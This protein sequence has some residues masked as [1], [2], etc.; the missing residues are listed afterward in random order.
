MFFNYRSFFKALDLA[1]LRQPF[2]LRRWAYV[3]FFTGIFL[4]F[5]GL[6]MVGR[7][8]DH[9]FAPGF[10]REDI[11]QP[12]FI[13]APPRSGTSFLQ[14][15]LSLDDE[16]FVHQKM[17]QTIFPSVTFQRLVHALVRL[18]EGL[19]APLGRLLTARERSWFGGW[20]DMHRMRLADPEEDHALFLYAFAGEAVFMLFPYVDELW[21]VG[22]PD[23]LPAADRRR[24]MAY[25]RSCLQRH[26]YANG[27]GRTMLVKSTCSSGAV[28][29]LMEAFPDAR[30]ITISRHPAQSVASHVSLYVPVWQ[31]H[32][33]EIPRDGAVASAYARLAVEW[34]RHLLA[35]GKRIAPE[36]YCRV[37]YRDL[38][39]D[40]RGTVEALYRHFGW[41]LGPS[42]RRRLDEV[43]QRQ[44][45]FKSRHAYTLEDFGLSEAWIESELGEVIEAYG[46]SE[47]RPAAASRSGSLGCGRRRAESEES[48]VADVQQT[49]E[50][51]Q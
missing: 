17:Y 36:R 7:A 1:L 2:R 33:P 21:E 16:R 15:L 43:A 37:D 9:V 3:I 11:P 12:V 25:Y 32:S 28:E 26:A 20:D 48:V 27:K 34:F 22:F 44:R 13:I 10:R 4:L 45:T 47:D 24:L 30:F 19:G 42:F 6:L 8:L 49:A 40:P 31:A 50:D 46:L 23:A 38:V 29:S 14:K 51:Q 18:D 35:F 41:A 39:R 5:R